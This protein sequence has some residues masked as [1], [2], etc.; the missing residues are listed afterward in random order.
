MNLSSSINFVFKKGEIAKVYCNH[1]RNENRTGNGWYIFGK[2][3]DVIDGKPH[4]EQIE[5][6]IHINDV[7][8]FV[9]I[10][11]VQLVGKIN[12]RIRK[13]SND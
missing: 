6:E 9:D 5:E 13:K 2:V 3:L 7:N 10:Y 12:F 8:R 1:E 4:I 11:D